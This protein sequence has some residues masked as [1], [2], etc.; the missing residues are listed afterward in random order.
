M[1]RLRGRREERAHLSY[2]RGEDSVP[3][4]GGGAA[5][6]FERPPAFK[7]PRLF[8]RMQTGSETARFDPNLVGSAR[9]GS[10]G[11]EGLGS[12]EEEGE[13]PARYDGRRPL[14]PLHVHVS[15]TGA[16][17]LSF[18]P[19]TDSRLGHLRPFHTS[20]L[21]RPNPLRLGP[22]SRWIRHVQ[23]DARRDLHRLAHPEP[24]VCLP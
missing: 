3:G 5:A 15:A 1:P 23:A 17:R 19:G 21:T 8:D 16:R 11:D 12:L 14:R 13:L 24:H 22:R 4:D 2:G 7:T 6:T 18:S 10:D 20:P 9:E